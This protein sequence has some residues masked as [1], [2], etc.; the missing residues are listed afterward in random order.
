[1]PPH[2]AT[3]NA[4]EAAAG[5]ATSG[6]WVAAVHHVSDLFVFG[7]EDFS[8]DQIAEFDDAF[9]RLAAVEI[10]VRAILAGRLAPIR[11]APPTIIRALA[12]DDAIEVAGP[13]LMQSERLDSTALL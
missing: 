9:V 6:D 11:N 13:V 8:D 5:Y 1:M 7:S 4:Q 10:S 12:F 3:I 2:D